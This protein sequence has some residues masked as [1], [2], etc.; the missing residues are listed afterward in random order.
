MS[1]H[2]L[3]I[4]TYLELS[5]VTTFK[6]AMLVHPTRARHFGLEKLVCGEDNTKHQT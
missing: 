5:V 2:V 6:E 1:I 4:F 3:N